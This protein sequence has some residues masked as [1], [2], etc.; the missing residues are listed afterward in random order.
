MSNHYHLTQGGVMRTPILFL[1]F[2]VAASVCEA[3][4]V[5]TSLDSVDVRC[6]AVSP[7]GAGGTNLF[8]GT[9]RNGV[10]LSTNNGTSWNQTGLTGWVIA[11][12][13]SGMNLF[14]GTPGGVFLSTNNGTSWRA[15]NIGLTNT[16]VR[17]F[18]L[19]DTNLFVGVFGGGVFLSTNN[20]TIWT[21]VNTGLTNDS[22]QA[23]AVSGSN[24]FAGT[25]GG[26]WRRPLSEMIAD[27]ES[28][29]QLPSLFA[30]QQNYPNPLN[31]S[32]TIE[33]ALPERAFVEIKILDV[34]GREVATLLNEVK[35]AG[36][37]TARWDASCVASGVYFYRLQAGSFVQTRKMLLLR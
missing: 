35:P 24:L 28:E 9:A 11:L 27:V 20:G 22:V 8:A 29:E 7:N 30:L 32:T 33:Y 37:Y 5:Q 34:L 15:V 18:A 1:M 26:V 23:L 4:W 10:F 14:A 13:I 21:E 36:T 19:S 12:A 17:S 3:Q 6:F 2:A 25:A 16:D 31:P